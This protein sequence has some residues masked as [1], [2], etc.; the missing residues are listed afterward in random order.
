MPSKM[1]PA[2]ALLNIPKELIDW[3]VS[4]PMGTEAIEEVVPRIRTS[5]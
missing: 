4:G 5:G 1:M 2:A 3:M